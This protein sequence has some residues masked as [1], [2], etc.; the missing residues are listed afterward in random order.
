MI[1]PTK[2]EPKKDELTVPPG[3]IVM[4]SVIGGKRNSLLNDTAT[5]GKSSGRGPMN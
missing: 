5:F 1:N 3:K 4:R 2:P